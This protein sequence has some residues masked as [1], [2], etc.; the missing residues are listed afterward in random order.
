MPARTSNSL[1]FHCNC[2]ICNA[3]GPCDSNGSPL[4]RDLPLSMRS[5]HQDRIQA[6]TLASSEAAG[7]EEISSSIFSSA[8]I[9]GEYSLRSEPS[10][11][12]TSRE[13]HHAPYPPSAPDDPP[14]DNIIHGLERLQLDSTNTNPPLHSPAVADPSSPLDAVAKPAGMPPINQNLKQERS[15]R[16]AKAH[17]S[18][19][20]IDSC[21][22]ACSTRIATA[23]LS[24]DDILH[25]QDE[26]G[27]LQLSLENVRRNVHSVNVRRLAT[28][29]SLNGIARIL[30]DL[31]KQH[32]IN[33]NV[34]LKFNSDHHFNAPIND[35]DPVAQTTMF[36]VILCTV[37]SGIGRRMGNLLLSL[38]MILLRSSFSPSGKF[39]DWQNDVLKQLPRT[40]ETVMNK[41]PLGAKT[42]IYA[43]CPACNCTYPPIFS[44]GSKT[45]VYPEQCN[46]IPFPNEPCNEV[47]LEMATDGRR[48]PIKTFEYHSF[49][50]Y[51]ATL[52]SRRDLEDIM[53]KACDDLTSSIKEGKGAPNFV[54][55]IFEASF[56]REF[57]GPDNKHFVQRPGKEGRYLFVLNV[58][59]FIAE[60]QTHPLGRSTR[61]AIAVSVNDLP[62]SRKV[63]Q[64]VGHTS[65]KLCTRCSCY[66]RQ[67]LDRTD[68]AHA[69]WNPK[70]VADLRRDAEAWRS[71]PSSQAQKKLLDETGLRWTEL[72][73]LPY[74]DPTCMLGVDSMHCLLEGLAQQHFH[75][76][77]RLTDADAK[78]PGPK[79]AF[80][81]TFTLPNDDWGN[82]NDR[83]HVAD[84]HRILLAPLKGDG[85]SEDVMFQKLA[86]RLFTKNRAS[87]NFVTSINLNLKP[88]PNVQALGLYSKR[89]CVDVLVA[90]RK[91]KPRNA[92]TQGRYGNMETM[93]R[94]REVIRDMDTPSWLESV[95]FNFGMAS[96][97]SLK[98]DEWRTVTTVHLPVALVSLWGEGTS[99]L[100]AA[101]GSTLRVDLD[102]TMN[103]VYAVSLACMR[104]M[105]PFRMNAYRTQIIS[106]LSKLR[107]IHPT[108]RNSSTND[109]TSQGQL[110][111]TMLLSF[112]RG[113]KLR[114]WLSRP[115]CPP[116]L[117]KCK[118]VFDNAFG[119]RETVDAMSHNPDSYQS[120]PQDLAACISEAKVRLRARYT[121]ND[122]IYTRSSTHVGNSLIL[123]YP[124]G[125]RSKKLVPGCIKYIIDEDQRK[126]FAVNCQVP[127]PP[128]TVDPFR[129]YSH[130][131][132]VIY[133]TDLSPDLE[134]IS[135]EW[136]GTH[137]ARWCMD[138]NR[139]V[140]LNLSRVR[141]LPT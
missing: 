83:K 22:K 27:R 15:Q 75:E 117:K 35:N 98:A 14:F 56:I 120:V 85:D 17:M 10:R 47:L 7:L 99:H 25:L 2:F 76:I 111:S 115:D 11:L 94:I 77:L 70:K 26:V 113:V 108:A 23:E 100:S 73:R 78:E 122:T 88:M 32:P 110:E 103:L 133:S 44:P 51:L 82:D 124:N 29:A 109:N 63:N 59:F 18:L 119:K 50:D 84:I 21:I 55:D 28:L 57:R 3:E 125:N 116:A 102:H 39:D 87:L 68:I 112:L 4:G 24:A 81:F 118:V 34:A 80:D 123:F 20:K 19:D 43:V 1:T 139:A 30:E 60:G 64:S 131:P 71:A 106:W 45:P 37:I 53:D 31:Q 40:T 92:S 49:H 137:Y 52:L 126:L 96:A 114:H 93:E 90:W 72:W 46:N 128:G 104:T 48:L 129:F 141:Y 9:G 13:S 42:T 140:V 33:A 134:L 132:A 79:Q 135:P 107:E 61:S 41:F 136:V 69:D 105:S 65:H 36:I 58:D 12:W 97:G 66:H 38:L 86:Q 54:S 5:V 138:D 67:K 89:E 74:W 62:A 91:T 101:V 16:T 127:A 130:F 95:P 121:H 8:V 6:A